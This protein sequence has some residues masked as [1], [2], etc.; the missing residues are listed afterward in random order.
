MNKKKHKLYLFMTILI[1]IVVV[2]GAALLFLWGIGTRMT[3]QMMAAHPESE[4]T[5]QGHL[6]VTMLDVGQGSCTLF[7]SNEHYVLVDGGGRA[8][9]EYVV[10]YLKSKGIKRLDAIIAT[11]YDEDHISGLIGVLNAFDVDN[12][13]C[14][15]YEND[16]EIYKSFL[17]NLKSKKVQVTTPKAKHQWVFGSARMQML[18]PD[19]WDHQ[20]ENDNSICLKFSCGDFSCI[21]TGDAQ[22][23]LEQEMLDSDLNLETVLYIAGHHGSNSSSSEPFLKAM[24]PAYVFISC[25]KGNTYGHPAK[26][27]MDRL[28]KTGCQIF[29][30]DKQGE[31]SAIYQDGVLTFS[32]EPC[33]DW[34]P[35]VMELYEVETEKIESGDKTLINEYIGNSKTLKLHYPNCTAVDKMAEKN[36][37]YMTCTREEALAKGYTPCGN[38]K[39]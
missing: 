38:C 25:G 12:C 30:S 24:K 16:T 10:A 1:C 2:T 9:S 34:T 32:K 7:K 6:E 17:K 14:L 5:N 20:E 8:S 22:T 13:L 37:V 33:D 31:V 39:P 4:N 21:I 26:E 19:N 18:A 11:H 28:Q 3:G 35:G 23:E 15:A 29:R 36:K 27:T